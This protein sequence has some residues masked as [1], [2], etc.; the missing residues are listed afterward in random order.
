MSAEEEEI[1][2]MTQQ[3]KFRKKCHVKENNFDMRNCKGPQDGAYRWYK[4]HE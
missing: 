2:F 4:E 3:D 1:W